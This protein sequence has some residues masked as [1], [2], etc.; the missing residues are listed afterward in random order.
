MR[1]CFDELILVGI[2]SLVHVQ[3]RLC[4]LPNHGTSGEG[5]QGEFESDS[6]FGARGP[7]YPAHPKIGYDNGFHKL[8]VGSA[9][10]KLTPSFETKRRRTKSEPHSLPPHL[11]RGTS[12]GAPTNA[13]AKVRPASSKVKEPSEPLAFQQKP[14]VGSSSE[15]IQWRRRTQQG[16]SFVIMSPRSY[17]NGVS[18]LHI[19]SLSSTEMHGVQ[20]R[21][22]TE[23]RKAQPIKAG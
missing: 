4:C 14:S 15:K 9:G 5:K 7:T 12:V 10:K 17:H 6:L 1:V 18:L 21:T 19:L 8:F 23:S 13:H 2:R 20:T 22:L 11:Q 16:A 3:G